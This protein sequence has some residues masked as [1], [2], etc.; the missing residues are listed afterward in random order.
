VVVCLEQ[1]A[2]LHMAQLTPLPLTV[3]CFRLGLPFW[4]QLT[5]VV[6]EKDVKRVCV[7]QQQHCLPSSPHCIYQH[8][9]T[10]HSSML[11]FQKQVKQ[12]LHDLPNKYV[13]EKH[14]TKAKHGTEHDLPAD[15]E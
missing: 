9:M 5:W 11:N 3:S 14:S 10:L 15:E 7:R 1:G 12:K 4:Y 13:Q 8:K 2:V 6:P